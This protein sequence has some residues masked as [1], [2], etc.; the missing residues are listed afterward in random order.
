MRLRFVITAAALFAGAASPCLAVQSPERSPL[1]SSPMARVPGGPV[2]LAASVSAGEHGLHWGLALGMPVAAPS[3]T[4]AAAL[5]P[6][7]RVDALFN[8]S[9]D[10]G[11]IA[12][13]GGLATSVRLERA[14]ARMA[15]WLG[16]SRGGARDARDPEARL[17]WG[18]GLAQAL[19]EIR[20]EVSWV[21]STVLFS[22][23]P[24]WTRTWEEQVFV[25]ENPESL[26]FVTRT[27]T[28]DHQTFWQTAQATLRW[29]HGRFSMDGVGG[30]SLGEGVT[31][32]RW[33]QARMGFQ[34][35]R[36]VGMLA[37]WG[38]RPAAA[39]AFEG[40]APPRT[41]LGVE[42]TPWVPRGASA[43]DGV[44]QVT[45]WRATP[46]GPGLLLVRVH[47]RGAR[48]VELTGD[49]TDWAPMA[50][51]RT[52]GGWWGVL[53]QASAGV[54]RVQVRVDGG[55]WTAPPGL[56]RAA[57]AAGGSAGVLLVGG[58]D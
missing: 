19:G 35:S 47:A 45:Q 1:V 17:R 16:V 12:P 33:A 18:G 55:A 2:P 37:A 53:L 29:A 31:A 23:D 21:T 8:A 58:E 39:L 38:E 27:E 49:V 57:D 48:A 15:M 24:R 22:D 7:W 44:P 14:S 46:A 4:G 52:N 20:G 36:H 56:P 10:P 32:R 51:E 25:P 41:M 54:H 40:N 28:V 26:I 3:G 42:L 9:H 43:G 11:L 6:T 5:R 13:V 30:L 34:F 50:L